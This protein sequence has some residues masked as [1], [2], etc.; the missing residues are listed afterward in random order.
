LLLN[1]GRIKGLSVANMHLVTWQDVSGDLLCAAIFASSELHN[2]FNHKASPE[3]LATGSCDFKDN[4]SRCFA[5]IAAAV[6]HMLTKLSTRVALLA[7]DLLVA[8]EYTL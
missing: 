6:M 8:T 2:P 3:V 7:P 5:G 1:G 4:N